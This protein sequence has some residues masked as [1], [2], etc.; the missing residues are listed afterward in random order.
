MTVQLYL[1]DCLES[2][3]TLSENSVDTCITD[4]PY[5]LGFMGKEWDTF[6]KSQRS[7]LY[8][9]TSEWAAKVYRVL[10]PG[11]LLLSFGSTRTYHRIVCGIE[12]AGF[13]IRDT[14]AWVYGTGFPKG[15]TIGKSVSRI[16]KNKNEA[17][18]WDGWY[19]ALKPAFEPIVIAQKPLDGTYAENALKWGVA[20]FWIDGGR[21]GN[22]VLPEQKTGKARIG[23]FERENMIT[24]ERTGRFSANLIHDGSD[25]V[26]ELFPN[27]AAR[28]FYCAKAS[29]RERNIGLDKVKKNLHPT[30]KPLLLMRYLV[31]LTKTPTGGV[32]L[33]PFMGTG[34]TG[35]A[36]ALEERDFIGIEKESEYYTI[37][38]KRINY[39]SLQ[40]KLTGIDPIQFE[41]L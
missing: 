2:L 6:D 30:V 34:T 35:I 14:V 32:V 3:D 23:T 7:K 38:E 4:P 31:R 18:L 33:D 20:G 24:P 12:D 8:D 5:G 26:I 28:F 11:A 37:A 13:E 9:F 29:T 10:K 21:V 15:Q 40:P 36:C 17:Q 19:T 1:G 41:N 39:W 22:E 25:E 16:V 27:N